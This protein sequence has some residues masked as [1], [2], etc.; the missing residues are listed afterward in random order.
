MLDEVVDELE[1]GGAGRP[2]ELARRLGPDWT[3]DRVRVALADLFCDGVV[4]H[5]HDVGFWWV[6]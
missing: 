1:R 2:I 3:E 5:S 4:G 6:A